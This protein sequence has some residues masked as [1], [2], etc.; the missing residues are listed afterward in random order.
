MAASISATLTAL[1][2]WAE[3]GAVRPN[4][5]AAMIIDSENVFDMRCLGSEVCDAP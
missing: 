5:A 2:D 3:R 1:R 4:A